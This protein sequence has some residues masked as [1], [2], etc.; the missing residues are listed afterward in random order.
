MKLLKP[1]VFLGTRI[2]IHWNRLRCWR[3]RAGDGWHAS[4]L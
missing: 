4:T 3:C 2:L 1:K